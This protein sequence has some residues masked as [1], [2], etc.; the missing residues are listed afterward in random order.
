MET[1]D[2]DSRDRNDQ[3]NLVRVFKSIVDYKRGKE[4][5]PEEFKNFCIWATRISDE[6]MLVN[7]IVSKF[8]ELMPGIL[9]E[10]RST[11]D[12]GRYGDGLEVL[13]N[14]F[15]GQQDM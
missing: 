4:V 8:V 2:P 10:I 7:M 6:P 1:F 5:T 11:T 9:A 13:A 3:K 14:K 15:R 12:G